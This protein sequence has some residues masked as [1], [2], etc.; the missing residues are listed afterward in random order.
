MILSENKNI[1]PGKYEI[2]TKNWKKGKRFTFDKI[3]FNLNL[4]KN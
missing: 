3:K 2:K 4:R 1:G